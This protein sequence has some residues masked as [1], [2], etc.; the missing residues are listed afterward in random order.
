V[1]D[2]MPCL[3]SDLM[4]METRM[5][6]QCGIV[7]GPFCNFSMALCGAIAWQALHCRLLLRII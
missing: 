3:I 4:R 1:I 5:F 2:T 6:R 7:D